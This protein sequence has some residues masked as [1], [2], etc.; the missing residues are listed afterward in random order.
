M[1]KPRIVADVPEFKV[2]YKDVFHLKNLYVMMHELL[3]EEGW[4]GFEDDVWHS[5]I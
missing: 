4:S 2:K 1:I 3:W 5:D